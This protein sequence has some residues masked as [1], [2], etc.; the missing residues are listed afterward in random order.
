[1]K[2]T[3][4]SCGAKYAIADDKVR[5]RR[6]KV[7]C[8]SC[9]TPIV[10]DGYALD[11]GA[12]E[13]A[14]AGGS[15]DWSVNLSDT[16]QR[17]MSTDEI[18]AGWHSGLVRE[19]AFVWKDGMDDWKPVLEVP[20]LAGRFFERRPSS[21]SPAYAAPA[22]PPWQAQAPPDNGAGA[23]GLGFG[24]APVAARPAAVRS[25]GRAAGGADLF[26]NVAQAG[27][28]EEATHAY[29]SSMPGS[30][31]YEDQKPTGARNENSV[32]FSLDALKAGFTP[33]AQATPGPSRVA[34]DT[35]G[36][37]N[38]DDLMNIGGGS[39]GGPL[40]GLSQNQALLHAPPPPPEPVR[41]PPPDPSQSLVPSYAPAAP[42]Q[43]SSKLIFAIGGAVALL[44]VVG[45]GLAVA[46]GGKD[47]K[48]AV[49][50]SDTK[51][52]DDKKSA[53]G[54]DKSDKKEAE[55]KKD[56]DRPGESEAKKEEG[57]AKKDEEKV[58]VTEEDKKRFADAQKKKEE[59][60]K[61][62]PEEEKKTEEVKK[63]P[64]SGVASFNKGA[65][66]A[67]LSS[68][69]A[70][71]SGCKRPGGPT[72]TGRAVVT[73]APSGNATSANVTGGSFGGTSVGGCIASVFR[74]AKVPPFEGNSVTVSKSFN[75]AP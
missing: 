40:F 64:S 23:P 67:A 12:S 33:A 53:S 73:F 2:V 45:V 65:A 72:G 5:G 21:P 47:E 44:L 60:A 54:D 25:S 52:G 16:D 26:G 27:N 30:Q 66:V 1:M 35:G 11:S 34:A 4:H 62:T 55:A 57:E 75:I 61:K 17:T 71:A 63:E 42:P 22:P 68:A 32:L 13:A 48:D 7:R 31:S 70:A 15:D 39:G 46:M 41:P 36:S 19:D 51:K 8:K 18:I 50:Q 59:E 56:D 20:E 14:P 37:A 9:A 29:P 28:E 43:K 74:R 69:A 58:P 24:S 38:L 49:A 3:C 6:V 10:V